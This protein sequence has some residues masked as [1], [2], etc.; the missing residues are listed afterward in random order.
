MRKPILLIACGFFHPPFAA[1][2]RLRSLLRVA[3]PN[4]SSAASMNDLASLDLSRFAALALYFHQ[5]RISAAALAAFEAFV[6]NGGGALALHSATAS[7][8]D[9]PQYFEI[10]GGRF[11]GHGPIEEITL[12]PAPE[13][14][15]FGGLP[16]FSVRDELYLHELQPGV[17]PH[18]S[19]MRQGQAVPL[20]WTYTYG[21]GRVCYACPGHTAAALRNPLYQQ[22]LKRGLEWVCAN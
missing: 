8:K 19:A 10:L 12:A 6:A 9:S 20:V 14:P 1:V 16:P 13:D 4:L 22:V 17:R 21:Q 2:R 7:F 15:I 3:C 5:K 18:F 11:T